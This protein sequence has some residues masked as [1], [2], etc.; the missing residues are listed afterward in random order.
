MRSLAAIAG[1]CATLA[2]APS[3]S[4]VQP[5][6]PFGCAAPFAMTGCA[7]TRGFSTDSTAA[8]GET[9]AADGRTIY[10]IE[11]EDLH[12]AA[13]LRIDEAGRLAQLPGASGC[14]VEIARA[15]CGLAGKVPDSLSFSPDGRFAYADV[16]GALETFASDPASGAL[17]ELGETPTCEFD[18]TGGV[19]AAAPRFAPDGRFAYGAGLQALAYDA[20]TGAFTPTST[21]P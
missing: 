21:S 12:A 1:C 4:L 20:A 5:P 19:L 14:L 3:G 10:Q 16:A 17:R 18:C 11:H 6:A 2:A 9:F 7:L 13:V 8:R 15:G